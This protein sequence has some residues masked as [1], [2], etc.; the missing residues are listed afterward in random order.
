MELIDRVENIEE[1]ARQLASKIA[2]YKDA[3]EGLLKENQMLREKL[4]EQNMLFSSLE[5]KYNEQLK[6]NGNGEAGQTDEPANLKKRIDQYILEID[7]C[8]EWLTNN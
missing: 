5:N 3:N 7:K 6:K 2:F 1:K 4:E 8:I